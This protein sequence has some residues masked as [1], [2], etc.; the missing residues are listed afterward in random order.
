MNNNNNDDSH[1]HTFSWSNTNHKGSSESSSKK[2]IC[3]SCSIKILMKECVLFKLITKLGRIFG[4]KDLSNTLCLM[5]SQ[6]VLNLY[7][8]IV[9]PPNPCL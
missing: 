8:C 4:Y 9:L 5:H 2:Q 7:S 1:T 3:M 6:Y